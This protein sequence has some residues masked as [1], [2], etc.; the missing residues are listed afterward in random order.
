[1]AG[2]RSGRLDRAGSARS[3]VTRPCR[4]A[5]ARVP[6]QPA[7]ATGA[8]ADADHTSS[9]VPCRRLLVRVDVVVAVPVVLGIGPPAEGPGAARARAEH[10]R[11]LRAVGVQ[12]DHSRLLSSSTCRRLPLRQLVVGAPAVRRPR[13]PPGTA[14]RPSTASIDARIGPTTA[15][16]QGFPSWGH[17]GDRLGTCHAPA[18]A[19]TRTPPGTRQPTAR[20]PRPGRACGRGP[21][22]HPQHGDVAAPGAE[23]DAAAAGCTP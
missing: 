14:R 13:R 22:E 15:P 20:G 19:G 18:A 17:P 23:A 4:P 11:P 3:A 2:P 5:G 21:V 9:G 8:R 6:R 12:R 1:M 16:A 10:A 7:P